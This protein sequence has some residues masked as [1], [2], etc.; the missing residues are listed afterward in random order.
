MDTGLNVRPVQPSPSTAVWT[1]VANQRA[2]ARTELPP[3]QV[4]TAAVESEPVQ[5]EQNGKQ[6][7]ARAKLNRV[8]DAI[9]ARPMIKVE[10]D[11]VTRDIVF[12]KVSPE[13]GEVVQQFPDEAVMRQ[14]AYAVQLRRAELEQELRPT[15]S[16]EEHVSKVA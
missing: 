15:P 7:A 11:E 13:T 5:F 16:N 14:R 4:V 9:E 3:T 1:E 12:R 10:Q 8:I 2:A 6:Q